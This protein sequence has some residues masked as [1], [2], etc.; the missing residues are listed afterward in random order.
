M[1]AA[2]AGES[3]FQRRGRGKSPTPSWSSTIPSSV[4]STMSWQGSDCL[5]A[6]HCAF[7]QHGTTAN[8]ARNKCGQ[9]SKPDAHSGR[10]ALGRRLTPMR[11][12]R[13]GRPV[14]SLCVDRP[15]VLSG[16]CS[17]KANSPGELSDAGE[18]S[19]SRHSKGR[20]GGSSPKGPGPP[21]H[22]PVPFPWLTSSSRHP[23]QIWARPPPSTPRCS[24]LGYVIVLPNVFP[25]QESAPG[26][27]RGPPR[28]RGCR[29]RR[30]VPPVGPSLPP[31][32][33]GEGAAPLSPSRRRGS[34]ARGRVNPRHS[35]AP[36][37]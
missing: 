2:G 22:T 24:N 6:T 26:E 20:R 34:R 32:G 10:A 16:R 8:K 36:S 35:L 9:T 27:R 11:G 18:T 13:Q 15:H 4:P 14:A 7:L 12:C 25:I 23:T 5:P 31:R 1:P 19:E 3:P 21:S 37:W 33:E 29:A 30:R 17:R 28:R